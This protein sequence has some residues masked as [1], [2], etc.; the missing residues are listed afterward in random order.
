MTPEDG[1]TIRVSLPEPNGTLLRTALTLT[2]KLLISASVFWQPRKGKFAGVGSVLSGYDHVHGPGGSHGLNVALDSAGFTA[3]VTWKGYPWTIAQYV[4]LAVRLEPVWW[5]QMD[6]CC[7]KEIATDRAEVRDRMMRTVETLIET[8]HMVDDLQDR[9]GVGYVADPMP[10]LQGRTPGDYCTSAS[11]VL[12]Y[13]DRMGR[14]EPWLLGVGSVCRRTLGG[15]EGI[16]PVLDALDRELPPGTRLHFF[17]A[18]SEAIRELSQHPRALSTDS[19]A[20][21]SRA[22]NAHLHEGEQSDIQQRAA[23]LT[24][25]YKRQLRCVRPA[26]MRE[27]QRLW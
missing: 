22:R 3:M 25:W 8:L 7:E 13:L 19:M 9:H 2:N 11:L 5:A 27:Q 24:A 12:N 4:D 17:G 18:E 10:V 23:H 6:Y 15:P 26:V 21:D 14:G 16:L 1:F 20:W